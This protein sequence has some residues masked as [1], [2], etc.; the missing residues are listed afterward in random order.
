MPSEILRTLRVGVESSRG[1]APTP[2]V[3]RIVDFQTAVWEQAVPLV[4]TGNTT[5]SVFQTSNVIPGLEKDTLKVTQGSVNWDRLHTLFLT[6]MDGSVTATGT[7]NGKTWGPFKPPAVSTGA[8][9]TDN[10]KSL[11]AEFGWAN[12]ASATPAH[13]LTGLVCNRWKL[14]F[15][16]QGFVTAETDY[17][18]IKTLTDITSFT[19]T[20]S[21]DTI[22]SSPSFSM[23]KY[24]VDES[25]IGTTEDT[26][27]YQAD[28]EWM[29]QMDIDENRK[30]LGIIRQTDWTLNLV[31]FYEASNLLAA[32]RAKTV[33]K[34]RIQSTGPAIG[35]GT[36]LLTVD[37]Y[38]RLESRTVENLNGFVTENLTF[39]PSRDSS[40]ATDISVTVVNAA[41]AA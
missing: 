6:S 5:G 33:E 39:K 7:S 30:R 22:V 15:T 25:T 35:S 4:R 26:A 17:V 16:P 29:G 41:T 2:A 24:Y 11:T 19:G 31:R 12:P 34:I 3:D 14:G 9:I 21:P 8:A 32:Y 1:T 10:L 23:H 20:L 27:V 40:A 28:L 38:G 36:Y 37:L 18:T 13:Q